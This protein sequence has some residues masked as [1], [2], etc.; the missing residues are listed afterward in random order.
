ML[1]L[2]DTSD[3]YSVDI[4]C[5]YSYLLAAPLYGVFLVT[6]LLSAKPHS[7]CHNQCIHSILFYI[8]QVLLFVSASRFSCQIQSCQHQFAAARDRHYDKIK[9]ARAGSENDLLPLSWEPRNGMA[10]CSGKVNVLTGHRLALRRYFLA[11][12]Q[13]SLPG[14]HNVSSARHSEQS[15]L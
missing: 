8:Y 15:L 7:P 10:R 9:V 2:V 6:L 3:M 14:I 13:R 5:R 11:P 1:I 12:L 4:S